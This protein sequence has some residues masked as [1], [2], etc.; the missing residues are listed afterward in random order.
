MYITKKTKK[1]QITIPAKYR[2]KFNVEY[3]SVEM[4]DNQLIIKPVKSLAGSLKKYVK[5]QEM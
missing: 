4:K 5:R 2:K 1:G 3:F